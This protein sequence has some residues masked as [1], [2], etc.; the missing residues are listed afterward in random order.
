MFNFRSTPMTDLKST[1]KK[2]A[3]DS[4]LQKSPAAKRSPSPEQLLNVA[5]ASSLLAVNAMTKAIRPSTRERMSG[6][7]PTHRINNVNNND[8]MNEPEVLRIFQRNTVVTATSVDLDRTQILSASEV[9][10]SALSVPS[11]IARPPGS[12]WIIRYDEEDVE[13]PPNPDQVPPADCYARV[14]WGLGYSQHND[15]DSADYRCK[16]FG[17]GFRSPRTTRATG[18]IQTAPAN[19]T[20][21]RPIDSPVSFSVNTSPNTGTLRSTTRFRRNTRPI[22]GTDGNVGLTP[23]TPPAGTGRSEDS[24][25]LK[26]RLVMKTESD[27]QSILNYSPERD[28]SFPDTRV[29]NVLESPEEGVVVFSPIKQRS[30]RSIAIPTVSSGDRESNADPESNTVLNEEEFEVTSADKPVSAQLFT[31]DASVPECEPN[32]VRLDITD[33]PVVRRHS[34]QQFLIN[35]PQIE[36]QQLSMDDDVSCCAPLSTGRA[37]E[38]SPFKPT[39]DSKPPSFAVSK[40]P[41]KFVVSEKEGSANS[42]VRPSTANR[43][44]PQSASGIT[45]SFREEILQV[46][47]QQQAVQPPTTTVPAASKPSRPKSSQRRPPAGVRLE[48]QAVGISVSPRNNGSDA[49]KAILKLC[50]VDP[51]GVS[52]SAGKTALN[53]SSRPDDATAAINMRPVSLNKDVES[54]RIPLSLFGI[55][56][57]EY[58][59]KQRNRERLIIPPSV[60]IPGIE[61]EPAKLSSR[62]TGAIQ[63]TRQAADPVVLQIDTRILEPDTAEVV[64]VPPKQTQQPASPVLQSVAALAS[65]IVAAALENQLS[66]RKGSYGTEDGPADGDAK[67][68]SSKVTVKKNKTPGQ[69]GSTTLHTHSMSEYFDESQA[70]TGGSIAGASSVYAVES[71][72][73]SV[74]GIVDNVPSLPQ[75]PAQKI[76][77]SSQTKARS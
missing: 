74:G 12:A 62:G 46:P 51:D 15:T 26:T 17:G 3:P 52:A 6:R 20:Q 54:T 36:L 65:A 61:A 44:R 59:E 21:D 11:P 8:S 58:M 33:G 16:S 4:R 76:V 66:P 22:T 39:Q 13:N 28:S 67:A 57:S 69:S 77:R 43:S 27:Y 23:R 32:Q 37:P 70:L 19:V 45:V 72:V 42:W 49:M 60:I 71:S 35:I 30:P 31:S 73:A 75:F 24:P 10:N 40:Q 56:E 50:G 2:S 68:S 53:W 41:K 63:N 7:T 55:P 38:L 9:A 18:G 47:S 48:R 14:G 1:P 34:G 25:L 64:Q 5:V 29:Y